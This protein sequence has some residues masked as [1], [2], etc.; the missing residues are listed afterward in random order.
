[1]PNALQ[2]LIEERDKLNRAIEA[3]GGT[4]PKRRGRP[5]G[6]AAKQAAK[7]SSPGR[8]KMSTAEKKKASER[9]KKY[10]ATKRKAA[11]NGA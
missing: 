8:P 7:K 9:M 1:M 2:V 11:K 10:W 6:K 5:P 3:L 4:V